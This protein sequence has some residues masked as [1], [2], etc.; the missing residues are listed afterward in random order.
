MAINATVTSLTATSIQVSWV[1]PNIPEVTHW[2]VYYSPSGDSSMASERMV[3]ISGSNNSVEIS[4]L[5]ANTDYVVQVVAVVMVNG[6]TYIGSQVP[7]VL[8][9]E[10]R[11]KPS[12]H[13]IYFIVTPTKY[14]YP[15][16]ACA[17]GVK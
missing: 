8:M 9:T 10:T 5:E 7:V 3:N 17:E 11:G 12:I 1:L 15:L 4:N 2:I 16:R 6:V 14:Y 13:D